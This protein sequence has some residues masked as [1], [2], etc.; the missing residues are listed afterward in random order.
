L[1]TLHPNV[2][3]SNTCS[4]RGQAGH[5][6]YPTIESFDYDETITFG[7]VG[8]LSRTTAHDGGD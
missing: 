2:E 1:A 7:H 8:A 6:V 4:A 5:G 3:R